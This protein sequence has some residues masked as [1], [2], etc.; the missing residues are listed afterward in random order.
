MKKIMVLCVVVILTFNLSYSQNK[1]IQTLVGMWEC[2]DQQN[3]QGSLEILDSSKIFISYM[4]EKKQVINYKIDFSKT[5]YWFSLTIKDNDQ[6]ISIKSF[7]YFVDDNNIK[8][9]IFLADASGNNMMDN[10][11]EVVML[12][13]KGNATAARLP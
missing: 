8:W 2:T 12:R 13:R 11:S 10:S 9:E 4:G 3:D 6:I 5:P 7:L 1:N